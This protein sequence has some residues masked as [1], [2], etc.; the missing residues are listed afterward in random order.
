VSRIVP[1]T[2]EEAR[3]KVSHKSTT[4]SSSS[5]PNSE[6]IEE[7]DDYISHPGETESDGKL[8]PVELDMYLQFSTRGKGIWCRICTNGFTNVQMARK[9]VAH[10]VKEN[11]L[12]VSRTSD[13]SGTVFGRARESSSKMKMFCSQ[14]K[15]FFD[16]PNQL[17]AHVNTVHRAVEMVTYYQCQMCGEMF[18]TQ[19][20]AVKHLENTHYAQPV[21][22]NLCDEFFSCPEGESTTSK[23]FTAQTKGT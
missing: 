22:C 2:Q 1:V 21:Q 4:R 23:A 16:N 13:Q 20:E 19:N 17:L 9:H 6:H 8:E 3:S 15:H 10:H 7:E 14:C 11:E 18:N 12:G 5:L